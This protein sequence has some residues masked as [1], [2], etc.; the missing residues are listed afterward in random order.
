MTGQSLE[1]PYRH[2][3]LAAD[4]FLVVQPRQCVS[5]SG[6]FGINQRLFA[7]RDGIKIFL[8]KKR[9]EGIVIIIQ[10]NLYRR[11]RKVNYQFSI[12]TKV[13]LC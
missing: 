10:Q 9:G 5:P 2:V 11:K 8:G 4:A 6:Q 1:A 12:I 13:D 7:V 3:Q